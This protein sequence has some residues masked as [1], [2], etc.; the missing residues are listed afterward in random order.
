MCATTRELRCQG[1]ILRMKK[2]REKREQMCDFLFFIIE[3][4]FIKGI[5]RKDKKG[6]T[7]FP[8]ITIPNCVFSKHKNTKSLKPQVQ[9]L[10]KITIF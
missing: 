8:S 4:V 6:K 2:N 10:M 5:Y 1:S 9:C 7:V 3:R